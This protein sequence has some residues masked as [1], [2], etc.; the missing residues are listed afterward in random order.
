M[1]QGTLGG[2]LLPDVM[3]GGEKIQHH[4]DKKRTKLKGSEIDIA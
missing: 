1:R 4:L 3:E 2:G